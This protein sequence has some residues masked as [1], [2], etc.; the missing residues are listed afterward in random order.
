MKLLAISIRKLKQKGQQAMMKRS[1]KG[2]EK[3]RGWRIFQHKLIDKL[4]FLLPFNYSPR[5]MGFVLEIVV[6]FVAQFK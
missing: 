5:S 2:H 1:E 6:G 3:G 4:P